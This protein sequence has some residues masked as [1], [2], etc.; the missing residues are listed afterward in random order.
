M[1]PRFQTYCSY[2]RILRGILLIAVRLCQ[3]TNAKSTK[4]TIQQFRRLR[5][6][7]P[8]HRGT[9]CL[10]QRL[11]DFLH[12]NRSTRY[13]HLAHSRDDEPF[14]CQIQTRMNGF[15]CDEPCDAY[16][17]NWRN[18]SSLSRL[19]VAKRKKTQKEK[20]FPIFLS[21]PLDKRFR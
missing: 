15:D 5:V 4:G 19:S 2:R 18:K 8:A 6:E 20:T 10:L 17:K 13:D 21:L 12:S 14:L 11:P 7:G 1:C 16:E 9:T 3:D